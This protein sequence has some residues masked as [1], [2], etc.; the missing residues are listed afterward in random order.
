MPLPISEIG[1]LT[2]LAITPYV[3]ALLAGISEGEIKG[4]GIN[5]PKFGKALKKVAGLS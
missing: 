4:A 2:V 1:E 5:Y 3:R